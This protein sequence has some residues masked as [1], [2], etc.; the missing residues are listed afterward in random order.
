MNIHTV[1]FHCR[2][3]RPV[4]FPLHVE[5]PLLRGAIGRALRAL[6]CTEEKETCDGCAAQCTYR[7]FFDSVNEGDVLTGNRNIPRPFVLRP[8]PRQSK[9]CRPGE[10]FQ[11]DTVIFGKGISSLPLLIEAVSEFRRFAAPENFGSFELEA[12]HAK[13]PVTGLR[14][15]ITAQSDASRCMETS[16]SM[17]D[18]KASDTSGVTIDFITPAIIKDKG[19]ILEAPVFSSIIK[20]L[21]DRYSSLSSFYGSGAPD[22]DYAHFAD[23]AQRV[24][25]VRGEGIA[26]HAERVSRRSGKTQD[27]SGFKGRYEFEGPVGEYIPLLSVGQYIHVGKAAA[28]GNGRFEVIA[29]KS[30]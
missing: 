25:L 1:E 19:V 28:F 7:F 18:F 3:V 6:S 10:L 2:A 9:N 16:F 8:F 23:D 14:L 5:G 21:R 27:M 4:S 11:F 20:R 17:D 12:V 30:V 13:S 26:V 15:P 24:K 29:T 22:I